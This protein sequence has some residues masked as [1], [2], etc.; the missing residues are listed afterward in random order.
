[1][2]NSITFGNIFNGLVKTDLEELIQ[3]GNG[4]N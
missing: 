4:K 3:E 2:Y 1:L